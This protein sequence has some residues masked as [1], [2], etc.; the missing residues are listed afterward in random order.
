MKT[1]FVT[2]G[3]GGICIG[4]L[5]GAV[6]ASASLITYS[7]LSDW[8]AAVTGVSTVTIPD[9][10]AYPYNT[11]LGLGNVSVTYSGVKFSGSTTLGNGFLFSIGTAFDSGGSFGGAPDLS[12]QQENKGIT[13]ILI[14]FPTAVSG[15]A[16]G[17]GDFYQALN[18]DND[19]FPV[20][21]KTS[22]GDT[23]TQASTGGA[24][25]AL[26]DFA[27][28]TDS[29]FTSVLVTSSGNVEGTS[30]GDVLNIGNISY[31]TAVAAPSVPEPMSFALMFCG[32]FVLALVWRRHTAQ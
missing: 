10:P 31:A 30:G 6:P 7:D 20:T 2:F 28:V 14:T 9:T 26:S 8:S 19:N 18:G 3:L 21:F 4:L 27:G 13:D 1:R 29:P 16:L 24:T 12:M 22:S 25:Y 17:Y 5:L 23:F 11:F 32:F 15:F